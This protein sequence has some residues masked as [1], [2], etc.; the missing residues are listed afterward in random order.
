MKKVFLLLVALHAPAAWSAYRCVDERGITHV[1]DTPPASCANVMMYEINNNGTVLRQIEPTPT[2][3]EARARRLALER[4]READRIAAEQKRK[5]TVLL[6]TFASEQE[7]DVVRDRSVEPIR[8][9]IA[10]ARDRIKQVDERSRVIDEELEFYQ[11]GK[12][13][14]SDKAPQ[15]PHALLAEQGRLKKERTVLLASIE[16]S[17]RDIAQLRARFDNDK[18]RWLTLKGGGAAIASPAEPPAAAKPV[19]KTY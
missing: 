5:D 9:R 2:P 4:K 12:S 8:S 11:A 14:R 3:E 15:V 7:F 10:I 6:S 13:G 18:R 1:G 16:A 19:R 17:E